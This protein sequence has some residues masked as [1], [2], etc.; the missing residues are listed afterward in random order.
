MPNFESLHLAYSGLAAHRRRIDTIGNNIANVDSP[1]YHRQRVDLSANAYPSTGMFTG[2]LDLG[3]GVSADKVTRLRDAVLE[4]HA[5]VQSGVAAERAITA[6]VLQQIEHVVGGLDDGGIRDQ[7]AAYLNAWDDLAS[8]PEDLALRRIV[9]Q[10]GDGLGKAV[11]RVAAE[12]DAI[13][14]RVEA[15]TY[16][17][18]DRVNQLT[19]EIGELDVEVVTA[20][21]GGASPNNL[22]DDRQRLIDELGTLVDIDVLEHT[23]GHIDISLDGQLLVGV[24][25]QQSQVE[26]AVQA[27]PGLAALGYQRIVVTTP[28]GRELRINSGELGANLVALEVVIPEARTNLN[29]QTAA[30]VSQVNT[31][32]QGGVGLDTSTGR[33][34]FTHDTVSGALSLSVDVDGLPDALAAAGPASGALDNTTARAIAALAE[35]PDGPLTGWADMVGALGAQ[36][37]AALNSADA[38]SVASEQA[39]NLALTVGGVNLDEELTDLL[40]AQRS[41]EAS[42]RLLTVIDEMLQTLLRT[43][44]VGR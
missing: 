25:G 1:G 9:L 11:T 18:V 31:L 37:A 39:A 15:D 10:R 42:A 27:D 20:L 36:V 43:G 21:N 13:R 3:A 32:H 19:L 26:V 35:D 4:N 12:I 23:D 5:R 8:A 16:D 38:A 6:D 33:D 28:Q 17:L 41:Y 7:T 14:G 34:F 40:T 24:G 2:R 22:L 30:L 44:L 29:T